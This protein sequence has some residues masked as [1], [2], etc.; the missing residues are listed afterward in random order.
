MKTN[1]HFWSYLAHFLL[2]REMLQTKV[3]EKI[4]THILCAITFFR[5]SYRLWD[6]VEKYCRAG[7]DTDDNIAHVHC[8]LDTEGCKHTLTICNTHC[9]ST[10][11]VVART[12]LNVNTTFPVL[13]LL[14]FAYSS[15]SGNCHTR[16]ILRVGP[17]M[18]L[19]P[20]AFCPLLR[21]VPC[22]L[23]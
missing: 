6:N 23:E 4:K 2:E 1:I 3:V 14:G 5:K 13:Y 17:A 22:F 8:V 15:S 10:T 9:Y 7:Q 12:R 20:F 19:L 16:F 21:T 18:L 11:T